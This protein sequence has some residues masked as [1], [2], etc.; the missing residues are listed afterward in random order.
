MTK[1]EYAYILS[2]SEKESKMKKDETLDLY[3]YITG[4]ICIFL[5]ALFALVIY[6][7]GTQILELVPPCAF[8]KI[9]GF[10]CPGCGGTRAAYGTA[11][12]LRTTSVLLEIIGKILANKIKQS[13]LIDISPNNVSISD[14]KFPEEECDC[15]G[16]R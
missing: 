2:F 1:N 5:L 6:I 15:C 13:M 3:F 9:T 12:L 7:F 8:H 10:Y 14:T 11:I 16:H 4:W